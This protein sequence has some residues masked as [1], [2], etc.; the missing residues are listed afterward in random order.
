LLNDLVTTGDVI[1]I[2]F[3]LK[4]IV[5]LDRDL[6]YRGTVEVLPIIFLFRIFS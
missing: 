6:V 5:N 2:S 3:G 1:A 4:N